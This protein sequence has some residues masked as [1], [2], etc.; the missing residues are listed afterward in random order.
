MVESGRQSIPI[1]IDL[2]VRS[3]DTELKTSDDH[4]DVA[5]INNFNDDVQ[6]QQEIPVSYFTTLPE[7]YDAPVPGRNKFRRGSVWDR[8]N[9]NFNYGCCSMIRLV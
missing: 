2:N 1:Q 8:D 3:V 7:G 4:I 9:P 6:Q 5:L